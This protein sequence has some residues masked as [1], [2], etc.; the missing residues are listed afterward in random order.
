MTLS[1]LSIKRHVLA[2]MF[3]FVFIIVGLLA[4]KNIGIDKY[5]DVDFPIIV[6]NTTMNGANPD[7]IDASITS[8]IEEKVNSIS[9]IDYIKSTSATGVSTVMINFLLEKDVEVAFNEVKAKVDQALR[10]LPQDANAPIVTKVDSTSSA[11]MWITLT[12]DRTLPQLNN[13]A[14]STLK[15]KL[16]TISG[17]G[18]VKMGGLRARNIRIE[19]NA[20]KMAGYKV[21]VNDVKSAINLEHKMYPG[22]FLTAQ[23]SEYLLKLDTEYHS[24]D[25]LR[26]LIV[27][28]SA[29]SP[30]K[31]KDIAEVKDDMEDNRKS[32]ML[33]SKPTIGLGIVKVKGGN[34]V[35]IINNVKE[36]LDTEVIPL[37]P[38]GMK[39]TIASDDSTFIEHMVSGLKEHLIS[40]T[41]LTALIVWFFLKNVRSTVIISIAIPVSLFG[42]IA[43]MYIFGYTFNKMT[44]LALLLLV[45]VVVDD[46]IV[47]LENIYRHIEDGKD[48]VRAAVEGGN[49]VF[50]AVL[51]A[52]LSLVAIFGP[53]MFMGGMVGRFF[54][55]F[56]VVVTV[57][58]LVSFFVSLTLT[59]MLCSRYLEKTESSWK[60]YGVIDRFFHRLEN[61]YKKL[62]TLALAHRK[63][64]L[65][66]TA[67]SL[68]LS[69]VPFAK[70][71]KGFVPYEDSG[72]FMIY[73][74]APLGSNIS[75]MQDKLSRVE[76]CLKN[77][78]EIDAVYSTIGSEGNLLVSESYTTV[79][80]C[81]KS[82]RK[83]GQQEI[84]DQIQ[85]ELN[86]IAGI[87]AFVSEPPMF[88]GGRG[89]KL[90]FSLKGP[91]LAET[92][93]YSEA[94]QK[95]LREH[96]ELGKMDIDM[97][98]NLP[99]L[100][101]VPDRTKISNLGLNTASVID[102]VNVM[103]GGMI[104]GKFNDEPG[105]GERYDIRLKGDERDFKDKSD[106]SK[107]YIRTPSGEL[108]RLDELVKI[109]PVLGAATLM[110]LSLQYSANFYTDPAMPIGDAIAAINKDAANILPSGYSLEFVGQ[111]KEFKKTAKTMAVTFGMALVLLYVVLASQFNSFVQPLVVMLAQPVAIVGGIFGLYLS[112][113]TLN[114]FSMIGLVLLIGLVA[115][116]SILLVDLTNQ[117]RAEGKGVDEALLS[118]CPIR[119]RPVLMTSM[120]IILAMLPAAIG[121]GAGSETNQ[122]LSIAVMFGMI[123]STLLTL[124][125]VPSAYSLVENYIQKRA[126]K[127]AS[128]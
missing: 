60:I 123:S 115:K 3:G 62:L 82:E 71:G 50:F 124:V 52:T 120:T 111:A 11:I 95:K 56:A 74:K 65:L 57:G 55:S 36:R 103:T 15:K 88:G 42:A 5:P 122:P 119:M 118:A 126:I 73:T 102:S 40:G 28:N 38:P 22:G 58:V 26:E 121:V 6:V 41:L 44:L 97:N 67:A 31:L 59:P 2:F 1:E 104:I 81:D 92:V 66:L 99:Q 114:I 43:I 78:P 75:Y 100:K 108:V 7:V 63:T 45:G 12:G 101:I 35:E 17:V 4:Y 47:V 53:V 46:A 9:G 30:I 113:Q 10:E 34:T 96:S 87:E 49:Q 39:L 8:I 29:F 32:A 37:L 109:E 80:L 117:Q 51:A 112:G 61:F 127:K 72:K 16:E 107:I 33:N 84:I 19:L 90:Q 14:K 79:T 86:H 68:L 69:F 105:D 21:A 70:I 13:Y 98:L 64:V 25:A 54:K 94:L 27:K 125:V 91:N 83:R 76:K 93:K 48:R 89:E 18:E 116:N 106:L 20:S 128:K 77:Y 85:R 24:V 110:R 23:K